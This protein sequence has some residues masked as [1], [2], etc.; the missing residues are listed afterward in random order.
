MSI[1]FNY[2]PYDSFKINNNTVSTIK[3]NNVTITDGLI[4]C[5]HGQPYVYGKN[6]LSKLSVELPLYNLNYIVGCISG[7][8]ESN[9]ILHI[10]VKIGSTKYKI[11]DIRMAEYETGRDFAANIK[12]YTLNGVSYMEYR[13][14]DTNEYAAR[15]AIETTNSNRITTIDGKPTLYIESDKALNGDL[16]FTRFTSLEITNVTDPFV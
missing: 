5:Y 2:T 13:C 14:I 8:P 15:M 1:I 6:E 7:V 11:D 9:S 3:Y 4:L 16:P 12:F 10:Y